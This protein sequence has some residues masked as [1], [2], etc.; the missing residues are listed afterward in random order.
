MLGLAQPAPTWIFGALCLESGCS[1]PEAAFLFPDII[2]LRIPGRKDKSAAGC[3]S[4]C[5]CTNYSLLEGKEW[6][7][8]KRIQTHLFQLRS[9]TARVSCLCKLWISCAYL[10]DECNLVERNQKY[11]HPGNLTLCGSKSGDV[12]GDSSH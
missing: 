5:C 10:A 2:F 11:L 3:T 7:T 1:W 4:P 8:D 9:A 12:V 6:E